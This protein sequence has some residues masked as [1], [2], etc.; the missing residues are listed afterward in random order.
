[1]TAAAAF[2]YLFGLIQTA[3]AE[4]TIQV[5][6]TMLLTYVA[7]TYIQLTDIEEHRVE[8]ESLPN[9]AFQEY[10]TLSGEV[11]IFEGDMNFEATRDTAF[12]VYE[13]YVRT[14]IIED[15]SRLG[16]IVQWIVPSSVQPSSSITNIGGSATTITFKFDCV[17]RVTNA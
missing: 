15:G 11:S 3:T 6:D 12:S 10:F 16:N 5:V 17:S 8:I 13:T 7:G 1:M 14:P 2:D 4:T 9:F